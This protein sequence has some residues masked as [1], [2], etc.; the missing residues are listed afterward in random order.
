LSQE[1][2][3]GFCSHHV[4]PIHDP[5]LPLGCAAPCCGLPWHQR[6][7]PAPLARRRPAAARWSLPP[8]VP[9]SEQPAAVSPG[10]LW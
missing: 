1:A 10:A 8:Q 7:H 9:E 4:E 6:A 3:V 2:A 5:H